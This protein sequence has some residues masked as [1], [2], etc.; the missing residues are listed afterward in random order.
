[1]FYTTT[2]AAAEALCAADP[3][4]LER[5]ITRRVPLDRCEEA[6]ERRKDDVKVVVAFEPQRPNPNA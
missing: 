2:L 3:G 1:M 4:W 6:F 5:L